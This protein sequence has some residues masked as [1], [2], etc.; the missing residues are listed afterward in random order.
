[1]LKTCFTYTTVFLFILK[2]FTQ[3]TPPVIE[4]ENNSIYCPLTQMS[5]VDSFSIN[6]PDENSI[7]ALHIQIS[8]GYQNGFDTLSLTGNHPNVNPDWD[9]V[10]GKLTLRG[11]GGANISYSDLIDAV[12]DVVFESSTLSV[13]PEKSLSFTIGD[14][15]YLPSTGHYYQYIPDLGISWTEARAA[16]ENLDYFGLQGYLATIMSEEEAQLSG[17]QAAGAGWI[18]GSDAAT[19]GVWEWVT[20]PEAGTVFWNGTSNG[21]SPNYAKWNHN[22]PNDANGGED[23]AHITDPSIGIRGAWNDLRV[24]GD[25]PGPYHPKG[26]IVEYGGMPGDPQVDLSANTTI[27]TPQIENTTEAFYCGNGSVTLEAEASMGEVWWFDD[28]NGTPIASGITFTTPVITETTTYYAMASYN[29]CADGEK[30]QVT[31]TIYPLPVIDTSIVFRNCDEDGTAD[32]FTDFNLA[33]AN[34][35]ITDT[36]ED[37]AF[38]YYLSQADANQAENALDPIFN[39][40]TAGTVYARVE[41]DMGCYE[42]GEIQLEV[43]T[44]SFLAGF[45]VPLPTCDDDADGRNVFD[46]TEASQEILD[47]FP[48]GQNLSVHYYHTL[49]DAHL[50]QDEIS[51]TQSYTNETPFTETLVVRVE[52]ED[53]GDCY[54]IGE[55]L[56][57]TVHPLP[58][59]DV[60]E[61][62]IYCLNGPPVTIA[63]LNP[64]GN[65]TYEWTNPNGVVIGTQSTV[66]VEAAGVYTVEATSDE[67]CSRSQSITV[68]ASS[69]AELTID[70]I[71]VVD[72][73][74]NNS[75]SIDP[76]NLGSGD[77]E[78]ALDSQ[79]GPYKDDPV[80]S[81]VAVGEHILFVRD[82]NGCGISSLPVSVLGYPKFFSPNN[83]SYNDLWNLEGFGSVYTRQSVVHVFDRYGKLLKSFSPE[84]PG[85]DGTLNGTPLPATDYWFKADLVRLNGSLRVVKGHF[86]LLR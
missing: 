51:N 72:A 2:G 23:Y 49:N 81:N 59:F 36:P 56:T 74:N 82:K 11:V 45:M 53:N 60:T 75:I 14:A 30:V 47:Q 80:F 35:Y 24:A 71:T 85:W 16:A 44:T 13:T 67:G 84:D 1:M 7:D 33:E 73:S 40:A 64:D 43:S 29:G 38:T 17:E 5:I 20:G 55:H 10:Q 54:G 76:S 37:F 3:D 39:N 25:P 41:T 69:V 57:L 52:S 66:L 32:G 18:G 22:E 26:Y 46:L 78:F 4:A 6:H 62:V 15:N 12:H 58:E 61:P 19:E 77:Y 68:T 27:L 50:E 86:S 9:A 34:A 42:V 79:F 83:D 31:A 48:G 63:V 65:Y 21:T 8:T 70:D 28:E